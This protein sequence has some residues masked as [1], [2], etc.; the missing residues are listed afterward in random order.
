MTDVADYRDLLSH[1]L[2]SEELMCLAIRETNTRSWSGHDDKSVCRFCC[3]VLFSSRELRVAGLVLDDA[4][5]PVP[6]GDN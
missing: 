5:R 6:K 1:P 3:G 2:N 4:G